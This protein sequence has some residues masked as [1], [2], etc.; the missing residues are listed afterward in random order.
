MAPQIQKL[1]QQKFI[2]PKDGEE[3]GRRTLQALYTEIEDRFR[4]FSD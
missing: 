4:A 2:N 3:D 1:I